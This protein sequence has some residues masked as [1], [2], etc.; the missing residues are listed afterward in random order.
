[1]SLDDME[2]YERD[3]GEIW[4][5]YGYDMGTENDMMIECD[6]ANTWA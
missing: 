5:E 3:M 4:G 6:M 2:K 1:M